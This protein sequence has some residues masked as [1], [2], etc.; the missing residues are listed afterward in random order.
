MAHVSHVFM[1]HVFIRH[2]G[3]S[4]LRLTRSHSRLEMRAERGDQ[5]G[6][7]LTKEQCDAEDG[8]CYKPGMHCRVI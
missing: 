8:V 6:S 7:S 5:E 4:K 1:S 3:V 2:S